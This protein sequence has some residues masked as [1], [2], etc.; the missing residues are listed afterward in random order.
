MNISNQF[1]KK[2]RGTT[3]FGSDGLQQIYSQYNSVFNF[4][5]SLIP[6]E[7]VSLS[8]PQ[9]VDSCWSSGNIYYADVDGD[10]VSKI[11][12]THDILATLDIVAPK[13]ISVIQTSVP[14]DDSSPTSI[15]DVGCW[16]IG[17][18]GDVIK[19]DGDLNVLVEITS[20]PDPS[21]VAT[22]HSNGGCYVVDGSF[23]L[24]NFNSNGDLIGTGS[25][26]DDYVIGCLSNSD[27]DF[28][29]L[30]EDELYRFKNVGGLISMAHV[31]GLS[32][33][34]GSLAIGCFDIDTS[35][36]D[37]YVSGGDNTTVKTVKFNSSNAYV[38]DDSF[39]GDFPYII[40]VSQHPSSNTFYLLTDSDRLEIVESSS[41]SS[42]GSSSSSSSS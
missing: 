3:V 10:V 14:M 24:L 13:S 41:S 27:G 17:A 12:Y 7:E 35:T 32:S 2:S 5:S 42:S 18:L 22:N 40:N 20:L 9:A 31:F 26:T 33:Y 39:S 16:I 37:I 15:D 34:F 23:G 30:T 25:F 19:T 28:F 21:L 36:D 6:Y 1:Y 38:A 4:I 8:I 11:S 29:V